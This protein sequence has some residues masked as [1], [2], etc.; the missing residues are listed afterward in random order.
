MNRRR[1]A[2]LLIL[3]PLLTLGAC[4]ESE[5][6]SPAEIYEDGYL[7]G[8]DEGPAKHLSGTDIDRGVA[9]SEC[10]EHAETDGVKTSPIWMDGCTDAAR[11]LAASLPAPPP[12]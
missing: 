2:A 5:E 3:V 4:A 7:F 11:D 8:R 10:G 12:K 1:G 6:R 9:E